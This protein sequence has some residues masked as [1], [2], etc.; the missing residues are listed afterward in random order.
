VTAARTLS[1]EIHAN[2]IKHSPF[3]VSVPAK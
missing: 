1:A 2:F 3:R